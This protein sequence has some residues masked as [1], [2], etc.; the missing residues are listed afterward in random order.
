MLQHAIV[1]G[2]ATTGRSHKHEAV[3][4]LDGVVELDD[5]CDEDL[6]WLHVVEGTGVLYG[7]EEAT[8]VCFGL[9]DA[10]EEIKHDVLEQWEI[11]LQEL[12]YIDIAQGTEKKLTLIHVRIGTLQETCGINDRAHGSH[13]VIVVVL[14]GQLLGAEL[15]GRD[16]LSCKITSCEETKRVKHDLSN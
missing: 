9:L 7:L 3:T 8:I 12:R 11:I 13:T 15:E 2:L 5:L 4:H 6:N 16:H 1:H 14:G 10:W